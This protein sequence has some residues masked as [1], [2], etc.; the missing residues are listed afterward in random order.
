MNN[1]IKLVLQKLKE[2]S[3]NLLYEGFENH[4]IQT[5]QEVIPD[6][7]VINELNH[8]IS[9]RSQKYNYDFRDLKDLP[10]SFI[11]KHPGGATKWPDILLVH[12]GIGLPIELKSSIDRRVSWSSNVPK[13][14]GLYVF[15]YKDGL[16]YFFGEDVMTDKE[17]AEIRKRNIKVLKEFK[18]TSLSKN[19]NW[20]Q[21]FRQKNFQKEDFGSVK[22]KEK[23]AELESVANN[24]INDLTWDTTQ[25][26]SFNDEDMT[27]KNNIIQAIKSDPFSVD[28]AG[29]ELSDDVEI[30]RVAIK[31]NPIALQ[32]F[33]D[34]IKIAYGIDK[35]LNI[36][37]FT[38]EHFQQAATHSN[39]LVRQA[40]ARYPDF[41]PD[42]S[43]YLKGINDARMGISAIYK[44]R[45]EE[46]NILLQ[47]SPLNNIDDIIRYIESK[48]LSIESNNLTRIKEFI[49]KE[50]DNND[51]D[52]QKIQDIIQL[53]KNNGNYIKD[54]DEKYKK[55]REIAEAAITKT[56]E[57]IQYIIDYYEKDEKLV[58]T[59]IENSKETFQYLTRNL[60]SNKKLALKALNVG[61]DIYKYLDGGLRKDIEL[62]KEIINR[63]K[64]AFAYAPNILKGNKKFAIEIIQNSDKGELLPIVLEL[65]DNVL[66][67]KEVATNLI[68]K[69]GMLLK[70][71]SAKS[72]NDTDI[73]KTALQ[74]NKHAFQY[75]HWKFKYDILNII[76]YIYPN[77]K[78]FKGLKSEDID[79]AFL[80]HYAFFD[81]DY[82][83]IA[84][85]NNPNFIPSEELVKKGLKSEYKELA[86]VYENKR[87]EWKF[88][89][90]DSNLKHFNKKL[91][92]DN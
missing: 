44:K 50:I 26:F 92:S 90:L 70:Y 19:S 57:S 37:E 46:W 64:C 82:L 77:E 38:E 27:N 4:F 5:V 31:K 81:N 15:N 91:L 89:S 59:A 55:I 68:K 80:C 63:Q 22:N 56:P 42:Q 40:V 45:Q 78:D 23:V 60:R 35:T 67:D 54:I 66:N 16:T 1:K 33:S 32:K 48:N 49:I 14:G 83:S 13:V 53:V 72:K 11:V 58:N 61:S 18:G 73:A 7:K 10:D 20:R 86:K 84:I 6:L 24:K 74:E 30:A 39:W 47:D 29:L 28:I 41:H 3:R 52:R 51:M 43:L 21:A 71:L 75:L 9:L 88:K 36:T 85:A 2:N 76:Q 62:Q 8:E 69:D 12:K 34:R 87:E 25:R 17:R 79:N 65:P